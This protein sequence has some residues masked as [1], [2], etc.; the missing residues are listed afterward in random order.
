M[1]IFGLC[2][3]MEYPWHLY[4]A[5]AVFKI[6]FFVPLL[7]WCG[8]LQRDAGGRLEQSWARAAWRADSKKSLQTISPWD[9]VCVLYRD[10]CVVCRVL[11][12]VCYV[13]CVV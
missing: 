7:S 2:D 6:A 3:L 8:S 10:K 9:C 1:S 11:C 12:V 4:I 5:V 13:L